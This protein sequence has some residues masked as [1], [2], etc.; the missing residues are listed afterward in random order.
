MVIRHYLEWGGCHQRGAVLPHSSQ[1]DLHQ[2]WRQKYLLQSLW[3][4]VLLLHLSKSNNYCG[5]WWRGWR[6]ETGEAGRG[7]RGQHSAAALLTSITLNSLEADRPAPSFG[8]IDHIC[9]GHLCV[10]PL[11][12]NGCQLLV[13]YWALKYKMCHQFYYLS[14]PFINVCLLSGVKIISSV[15]CFPFFFSF[16]SIRTRFLWATSFRQSLFL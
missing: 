8:E 16:S 13:S 14:P 9:D 5:D 12:V 7:R 4:K 3:T 11:L 15:S 6:G 10:P 1:E 2:C